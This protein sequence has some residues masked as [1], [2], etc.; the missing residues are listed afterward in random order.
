MGLAIKVEICRF[1]NF[2]KTKYLDIGGLF[3]G[4]VGWDKSMGRWHG[5]TV[6]LGASWHLLVL[7]L[8]I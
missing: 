6:C 4:T 7:G 8:S 3:T 2:E 1:Y 5:V